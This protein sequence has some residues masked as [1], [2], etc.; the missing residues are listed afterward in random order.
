MCWG[1][2]PLC[3]A[4]Y[5]KL[6][7]FLVTSFRLTVCLDGMNGATTSRIFLYPIL[8]LSSGKDDRTL[9]FGHC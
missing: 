2:G 1:C 4:L 6:R 3:R 9:R 8:K 7:P 5:S